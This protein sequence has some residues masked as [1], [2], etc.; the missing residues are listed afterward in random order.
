MST[1]PVSVQL[2]G[3]GRD[4][5]PITALY[6]IDLQIEPG[7]FVSLL[8]PSGCGKTTTLRLVAG[9]DS[10]TRGRILLGGR[11]VTRL[12][13]NRRKLGM[14]FQ[15]Y[16]LFPHMTVAENIGFGLRMAGM[17]KGRITEKV[18]RMLDLIHLSQHAERMPSQL[19]GGQQQR[20]AIA[21]SLVTEPAVLLLD[22]PMGA[23]DKNLRQS[24]Q[25]ELR[26]IQQDF[27][28]TAV[29]VTHDQ[30]E[31]LTMSDKV[32]VMEGGH[33][34]QVGTPEEIYERPTSGFVANFLGA[35]NNLPA[36][37]RQDGRVE[38]CLPGLE[39]VPVASNGRALSG[40]VTLGIR[41]ERIRLS[42]GPPASSDSMI[43]LPGTISG[44]VFRGAC[45]DYTV[46]LGP[47]APP[48]NVFE[49]G[50]DGDLGARW[51]PGTPVWVEWPVGAQNLFARNS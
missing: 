9:F 26:Q 41:P 18:R 11:D 37:A 27:Q 21:R 12:P 23:L 46:S 24:M 3:V 40:P 34:R 44:H 42:D 33:I 4:F 48:L 35:S 49:H 2:E 31:A 14:V 16:A 17:D 22:E 1:S 32:V 50:R 29:L 19:S 5:G 39:P 38:L 15:N 20:V 47:E 6:D 8:G 43:V 51:A 10:P 7:K 25:A 30:D 13:P 36:M 28:I 45:H